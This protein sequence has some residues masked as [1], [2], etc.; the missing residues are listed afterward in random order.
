MERAD[1]VSRKAGSK[2]RPE[3][4]PSSLPHIENGP[5]FKR[6]PAHLS[7]A[8]TVSP[9]GIFP[10]HWNLLR[11]A[12][13]ATED[14]PCFA[15]HKPVSGL[16]SETREHRRAQRDLFRTGSRARIPAPSVAGCVAVL[17]P[18]RTPDGMP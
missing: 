4:Q 8:C 16:C 17:E 13:R 5:L 18:S 3:R 12:L 6:N 10:A 7:T 9:A 15:R 2:P 14:A 1:K 11:A